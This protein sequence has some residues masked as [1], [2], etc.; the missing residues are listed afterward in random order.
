MKMAWVGCLVLIALTASLGAKQ[1]HSMVRVH[2]EANPNDGS[3]FT[4]SVHAQ[5]SGKEIAIEKAARITEMDVA[6]FYPYEVGKNDYGALLQLDD[7]GTIVLD[8]LSVERRGNLLFVF[9]NGRPVTELQIDKRVSD[10]QIY[11]ASG[12][13]KR[14]IDAMKQ[15]W[16]LI[17][18][19]K[20]R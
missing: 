5:F 8:S 10:G 2:V 4:S 6:A 18:K 3:S 19:K 15:D 11:I 9:I 17:G 13:T 1:R 16:P 20:K 7:H 14:D 12:L